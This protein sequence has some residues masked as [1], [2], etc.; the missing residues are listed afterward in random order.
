MNNK[1]AV[2]SNK[3]PQICD[4]LKNLGY[5]LIYTE[6]V[7]GFISYEQNHADMQVLCIDNK[8][9][10]LSVCQKLGQSLLYEGLDVIFTSNYIEGRYP[11]NILLNAKIVGNNIIG[12]IN[13]LDIN[14]INHC[15]E[16]GYN[17]INVNQGYASCSCV[18]IADN[19]IITTDDSIYKV[20]QGT[21]IDVLRISNDNITL[22]GA[23]KGTCGFI[24]GACAKLSED[25]LLFFG[26]I[27]NHRDYLSIK[28]FSNKYGIFN[29]ISIQDIPLTDIGGAILLKN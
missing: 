6:S 16:N 10:V 7:D 15:K 21:E 22:H 14:L 11:Y 17:L 25:T 3:V 2:I 24:G 13:S 5:K 27:K 9:F 8:V 19:A 18:G 4:T 1:L 23:E 28:E 29:I 12:K 26:D 20:L